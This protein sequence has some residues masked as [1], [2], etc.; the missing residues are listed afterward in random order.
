M[1]AGALLIA[2]TLLG[3]CLDAPNRSGEE[4]L[5]VASDGY[6]CVAPKGWAVARDRGATIFTSPEDSRRTIAIR[7]VG[8]EG[9]RSAVTV[10][11]D[12]A[13][14]VRALP[15][16]R[17]EEERRFAGGLGGSE[18]RLTFA[19]PTTRDR[20]ARRHILLVGARHAFQVIETHPTTSQ[21]DAT[22]TALAASLEE[23]S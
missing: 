15:G 22:A 8:F 3:G 7:A 11:R 14:V 4:R 16:V 9:A 2:A 6:T 1:R 5:D 17:V 18:Y 12:T 21:T 19:P 10:E 13:R 23:E 20:M